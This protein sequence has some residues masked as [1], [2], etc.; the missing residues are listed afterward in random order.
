MTID[1]ITIEEIEIPF[2]QSFSHASAT[3]KVTE[4]VLVKAHS[5]QGHTG[6]GEGCPR[7][8]VTG[9]TTASVQQFFG[10]SPLC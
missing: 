1:L 5:K 10:T 3:R 9:E 2:K 6:Y 4:A 7:K 8:Y